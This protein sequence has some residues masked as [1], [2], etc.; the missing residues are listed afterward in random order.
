MNPCVISYLPPARHPFNTHA[1][2][3]NLKKYRPTVPL[4]LFSDSEWPDADL[5]DIIKTPA[6]ER[7]GLQNSDKKFAIANAIFLTAVRMM[8]AQK[9]DTML[10]LEEDTRMAK[11]GWDSKI[12]D[13]FAALKSKPLFA[14]SLVAYNPCNAG[15]IATA[16]FAKWFSNLHMKHPNPVGVFGFKG[17]ADTGGT[18]IFPMGAG[19]IYTEA[20]L[21]QVFSDEDLAR[22]IPTAIKIPAFDQH[23]GLK[24][25]E[26]FG[27]GAYN[28]VA[29]L[30]T[31]YST[32]GNNVL[33]HD[34][35][36]A[37]LESGKVNLVHPI[38]TSYCP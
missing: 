22:T 3:A 20:G 1:F 6:P 7:F 15:P 31:V 21:R 35:R 33:S 24:L 38:K 25:W 23:V 5:G 36:V 4:I 26:K 14:G 12:F 2:I 37:L 27:I 13:E 11:D 30:K 34:Q 10:Y 17:A 8:L 9:H 32:Y 18:A 16:R 29:Q 28:Q 19:A